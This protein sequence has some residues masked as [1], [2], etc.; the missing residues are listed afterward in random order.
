MKKIVD[1]SILTES[2]C[3][4][5]VSRQKASDWEE[6]LDV[7]LNQI[8]DRYSGS[9]TAFFEDLE[10][11]TREQVGNGTRQVRDRNLVGAK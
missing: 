8:H 11:K 5:I 2:R 10:R 1:G 6:Q 9:L 3:S 4:D 7:L